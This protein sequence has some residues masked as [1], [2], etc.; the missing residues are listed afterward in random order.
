MFRE[1]ILKSDDLIE[2]YDRLIAG[3]IVLNLKILWMMFVTLDASGN[4]ISFTVLGH[5]CCKLCEER[6]KTTGECP[7]SATQIETQ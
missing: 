6:I 7:P 4:I 3:Q 2:Q 5:W 1:R